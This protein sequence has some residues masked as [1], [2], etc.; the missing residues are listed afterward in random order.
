MKFYKQEIIDL[1]KAWVIISLIFAIAQG[2]TKENI[3]VSAVAVGLGFVCHE[4]AHKM[5]AQKYGL[6]AYFQSFDKALFISFV[7]SIFGII[8]IAPGAVMVPHM[9]DAVRA[10]RIS[11]AGP[12]VNILLALAFLAANFVYPMQMLVFGAY[13]NAFLALFNL[14]PFFMFD[15]RK[16]RMWNKTIHTI[17][18]I[19]AAILVFA[20]SMI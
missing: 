1:V 20:I 10:G 18:L 8:F 19:I 5:M 13:I 7:L 12:I 2:F 9:N 3:I 17:L 16:I 14:I 15:G 11:A 4:L 6:H